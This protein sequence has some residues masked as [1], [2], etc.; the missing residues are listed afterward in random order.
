MTIGINCKTVDTG[1]GHV[2]PNDYGQT[3]LHVGAPGDYPE[4]ND[5][6][7][8]FLQHQLS[9]FQAE[10]LTEDLEK[11]RD[12]TLLQRRQPWT[13]RYPNPDE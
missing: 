10:G 2:K 4:G 3:E 5:L 9:F 12:Q 8:R 13:P 6:G 1:Q 11:L 7:A